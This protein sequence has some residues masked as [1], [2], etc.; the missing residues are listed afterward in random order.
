MKD[1]ATLL[2]PSTDDPARRALTLRAHI[3]EFQDAISS[4]ERCCVPVI[5]A[6]HGTVM[7]LGVDIACACDVR[8]AS[9]DAVF[10]I[11]VSIL[12]LFS[13]HEARIA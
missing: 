4:I 13:R 3:L 6:A 9:A 7:G 8:Y 12:H 10:S 1:S 5:L 2:T 11:K